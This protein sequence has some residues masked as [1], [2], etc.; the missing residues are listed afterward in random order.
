MGILK[1]SSA[2]ASRNERSMTALN[3]CQKLYRLSLLEETYHFLCFYLGNISSIDFVDPFFLSSSLSFIPSFH[4]L[5]Q[6]KVCILGVWRPAITY[7]VWLPFHVIGKMWNFNSGASVFKKYISILLTYTLHTHFCF[8]LV[9]FWKL[10]WERL[11]TAWHYKRLEI[12]RNGILSSQ[13][14]TR[15]LKKE[16]IGISKSGRMSFSLV[17]ISLKKYLLPYNVARVNAFGK[18][19]FYI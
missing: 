9:W 8:S 3:H 5:C 17:L 2:D 6:K 14:W 12:L 4:W 10:I 15:M 19:L 16:N 13:L 11:K 7:G 18:F 1:P